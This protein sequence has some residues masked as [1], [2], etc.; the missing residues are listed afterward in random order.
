METLNYVQRKILLQNKILLYILIKKYSQFNFIF[1][2]SL[3]SLSPPHF[4]ACLKPGPGFATSYIV[5]FF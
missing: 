5:V 1:N 3:T 4:Y 2:I